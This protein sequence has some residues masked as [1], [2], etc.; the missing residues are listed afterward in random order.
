MSGRRLVAIARWFVL[1]AQTSEKGPDLQAPRREDGGL[2]PVC[3]GRAVQT[4][5]QTFAGPG[6]VDSFST[7][8]FSSLATVSCRYARRPHFPRGPT[9]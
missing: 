7:M 8:T 5:V 1:C 4:S 9:G 6:Q 3:C 2:T